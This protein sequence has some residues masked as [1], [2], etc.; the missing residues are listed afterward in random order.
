MLSNVTPLLR[1]AYTFGR[2]TLPSGVPLEPGLSQGLRAADFNRDGRLDFVQRVADADNVAVVLTGGATVVLPGP[3]PYAGHLIEDFNGDGNVDVLIYAID[4]AGDRTELA[5]YLGDGRGHFRTAPA[6]ATGGLVL[7]RC[8][9]GDMDRD[10]RIDL[11]CGGSDLRVPNQGGSVL[12]V[13]RGNGNG[14]FTAGA[15][16]HSQANPEQL[17]DVNQD[18]WLDVVFGCAQLWLGD[19]TGGF[20]VPVM[21][22]DITYYSYGRA[23]D[24]NHDGYVDLVCSDGDTSL[25]LVPGG[26]AGFGALTE[27]YGLGLEEHTD[28]VI[29][30]VNV[31]GHLDIVLNFLGESADAAGVMTVVT[32]RGDGTFGSEPFAMAG[33][34][35]LVADVIGDGAAASDGLPDI[36][37]ARGREIVVLSNRRSQTNRPPIITAGNLTIDYGSCITIPVAASDPD[38]HAL[39]VTWQ[40]GDL[41]PSGRM[42]KLDAATVCPDGPGTYDYQ[43]TVSDDRGAS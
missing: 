40:G 33:G 15:A 37:V 36:V 43:L 28:F 4:W 8:L 35:V 27:I 13:M 3:S 30:D 38:Q 41:W 25:A 7:T 6:T 18:G 29:A 11:V 23:A 22:S 21:V 14:T 17:A 24:M 42:G 16:V 20:S 1:A 39:W 10:G 26:A 2:S 19:G 31:D 9:A 32:G 34:E 12:M 5:V